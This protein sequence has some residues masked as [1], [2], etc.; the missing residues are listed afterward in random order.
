M[1]EV[2]LKVYKFPELSEQAKERAREWWRET[3]MSDDWHQW[4]IEDATRVFALA[5]FQIKEI[6]YTGFWSQGDGAC[7]VGS[8]GAESTKHPDEMKDHAPEDTELHAIATQMYQIAQADPE[9]W[10]AVTHHGMN[11]HKYTAEFEV[12]LGDR[13]VLPDLEDRIIEAA[14][15]AMQW[16][17]DR[18]EKEYEYQTSAEQIDMILTDMQYEFTE[19]GKRY[20]GKKSA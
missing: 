6:L 3:Q 17:Y 19:T 5:G 2:K 12:H 11:Y 13:I 4:V 15:E 18:L 16:I 8:W 1:R 20:V 10:A 9:A 7:F 14:R